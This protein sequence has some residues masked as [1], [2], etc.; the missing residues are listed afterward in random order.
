MFDYDENDDNAF[1]NLPTKRRNNQTQKPD[2]ISDICLCCNLVELFRKYSNQPL[3]VSS[4]SETVL[5]PKAVRKA[6]E[7][8]YNLNE[9]GAV[10]DFIDREMG[11][12]Q[13]T[14]DGILKYIHREHVHPQYLET[15]LSFDREQKFQ[16]DS[17][18]D[19]KGCTPQCSSHQTFGVELC[20]IV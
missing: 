20:D 7:K 16:L 18:L 10:N 4:K 11:C 2:S 3:I 8:F 6:L 13:E 5:E 14:L 1:D 17:R 15:Y 12:A 19:D 9:Q